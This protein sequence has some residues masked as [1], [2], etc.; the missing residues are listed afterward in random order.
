MLPIY[1]RN[2]IFQHDNAPGH[3]SR[4]VS[5]FMDNCGI[6]CLSD[7]PPQSLDINIIEALWSDLKASVAK[8]RPVNIKK[9]WR[10]CEDKWTQISVEKNIK[11]VSKPISKDWRGYENKR[12]NTD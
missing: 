5:S 4:V 9:L 6:C 2:D 1:D 3:K 8:C 11:T 12:K 10:T 7:W